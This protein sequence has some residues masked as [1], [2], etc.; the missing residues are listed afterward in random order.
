MSK[1]EN[2]VLE[3]VTEEVSEVEETPK[4]PKTPRVTTKEPKDGERKEP[5][6][7]TK[8]GRVYTAGRTEEGGSIDALA[9]DFGCTTS[10]VRQ[11]IAQCHTNLG[12]GYTLEGDNFYITGEPTLTW[13]DQAAE[14]A[15]KAKAKAAEKAAAK[16]AAAKKA[17]EGEDDETEEGESDISESEN[18]SEDEDFLD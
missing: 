4:T 3:D 6:P 16:K 10:N 18:T 13:E 5:N 8:K 9:K 14:K 12:F 7:S 11:H 2:E 1:Q 17:A 15:E